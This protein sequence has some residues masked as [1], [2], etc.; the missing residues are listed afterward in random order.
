MLHSRAD[1]ND[2]VQ[3]SA[4]IIPA[5]EPVF[6]LRAQD[7]HAPRA[8][9]DWAAEVENATGLTDIVIAALSQAKRMDEWQMTHGKKQ[10]DL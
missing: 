1:Y 8:V 3:D 10:P 6:L 7:K 5:D 4:N 9:R 2:R